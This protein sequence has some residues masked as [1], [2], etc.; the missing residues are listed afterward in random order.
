WTGERWEAQR[1]SASSSG[2]AARANSGRPG[3]RPPSM[4]GTKRLSIAAPPLAWGAAAGG[5]TRLVAGRPLPGLTSGRFQTPHRP[6]P[7]PSNVQELAHTLR[8]PG[9]DRA[10]ASHDDGPLHELRVRGHG[11]EDLVVAHIGAA[12]AELPIGG[13]LGPQE[14]ARGDPHR[15]DE[16]R[17]L[18]AG[19]RVEE[20]VHRLVLDPRLTQDLRELPAGGARRLFVDDDAFV[21]H[22]SAACGSTACRSDAHGTTAFRH[23]SFS[24]RTS[25]SMRS[26]STVTRTTSRPP[27]S[28]RA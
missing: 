6:L 20:V 10:V 19:D 28:S 5:V 15:A 18:V 4:A 21:G 14:V 22:G 12:E 23:V 7:G 17:Q 24:R 8:G 27:G 16:A 25:G 13:L 26:G 2:P 11:V 9:Q 3:G 1:R